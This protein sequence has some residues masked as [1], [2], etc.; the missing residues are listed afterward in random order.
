MANKNSRFLTKAKP[1][2]QSINSHTIENKI[3]LGLFPA[4]CSDLF[5][6]LEFIELPIRKVLNE[7]GERINYC[8][9]VNSGL[10][11]VLN[12]MNDGKSVE[13]GLSGREGFVGLPV[14]VGFRTSA[15][16]AVVQ[17]AATA[18]RIQAAKLVSLLPRCPSLRY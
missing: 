10:V 17:I 5:P 6:S 9:F 4:H 12:V 11:S 1:P 3:L 8:Y 15:S 16:R 14:I 18:L 2:P 7:T 13:V